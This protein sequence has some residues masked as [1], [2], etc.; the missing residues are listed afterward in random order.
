MPSVLYERQS[1]Q[2]GAAVAFSPD[3]KFLFLTAGDRQR[4]TLAQGPNQPAGKILRLPLDGKPAP[5]NPMEG[6]IGSQPSTGWPGSTS[7]T[8]SKRLTAH[9]G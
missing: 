4:F 5:G 2:V 6:K 9:C 7:A 1:G 8:S 3:Q